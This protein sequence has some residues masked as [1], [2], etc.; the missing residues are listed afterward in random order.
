MTRRD[1]NYSNDNDYGI[2]A[3]FHKPQTDY[4]D[5]T[6][7]LRDILTNQLQ[8]VMTIPNNKCLPPFTFV[9]DIY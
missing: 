9:F 1:P 3:Y 4:I 8:P 2:E 7:E 6:I 5:L